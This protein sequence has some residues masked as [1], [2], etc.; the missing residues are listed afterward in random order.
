[1]SFNVSA[2]FPAVPVNSTGIRALKSPFF[3]AVSVRNNSRSK[4]FGEISLALS[5]PIPVVMTRSS[6]EKQET[7][8]VLNRGQ[9]GKLA[10]LVRT[11]NAESRPQMRAV[12]RVARRLLGRFLG[13]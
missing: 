1:M 7:L 10:L 2:I 13:R 6:S 11:G 9:G 8:V 3:I 12:S 5:T 4:S